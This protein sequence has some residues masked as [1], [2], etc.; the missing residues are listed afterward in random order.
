MTW[1][2]HGC[3]PLAPERGYCSPQGGPRVPGALPI[4]GVQR[5]DFVFLS[6]RRNLD[7]GLNGDEL[8][9]DIAV[10]PAYNRQ[11]SAGE[12][13]AL[14]QAYSGRFNFLTQRKWCGV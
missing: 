2:H 12:V 8:T 4:R 11:L 10:L 7:L 5:L 13:E 3:L 14:A 6:R 1:P 9:G